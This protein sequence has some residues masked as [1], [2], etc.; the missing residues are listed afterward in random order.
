MKLYFFA[1]V[2]FS[3]VT[4][5][6][7]APAGEDPTDPSALSTAGV[8][9]DFSGVQS[10]DSVDKK[11]TTVTLFENGKVEG[12]IVLNEEGFPIAAYDASGKAIPADLL[13]ADDDDTEGGFQTLAKP[14]FSQLRKIWKF[15]K[16]Y[17]A[18]AA[19]RVPSIRTE[20]VR[21]F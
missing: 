3:L 21:T 1:G 10:F 15:I 2:L 11:K 8:T 4:A 20:L 13:D 5:I 19:V 7:A 16:K 14:S 9:E 18:R 12:R 17:G 6:V